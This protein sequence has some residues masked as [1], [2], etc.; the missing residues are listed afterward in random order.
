[1]RWVLWAAVGG[2]LLMGA[3]SGNKEDTSTG[4][5]ER[6][7]E[8]WEEKWDNGHKELEYQYYHDP[9]GVEVKHGYYREYSYYVNELITTDGNYWEG[10]KAGEWY[11]RC[12]AGPLPYVFE[13]G[14][15]EMGDFTGWRLEGVR[16]N[17]IELVTDESTEKGVYSTRLTLYP[18][19]MI[20]GG[21]RVE[22][23]RLDPDNL[24]KE[25]IYSWSFKVD[26][27]YKEEPYWQAICQFHSQPDS[28]TGE[29]WDTYPAYKPPIS[30]L[31]F[32]RIC[33]VLLIPSDQIP[34]EIGRFEI[35]KGKWFEVFFQIKWSTIEDGYIEMYV[36]DKPVTPF[37]GVDHKF[38]SSNVNNEA[39]NYLKIGLYRDSRATE[40]NTVYVDDLNISDC[41]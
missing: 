19:D 28:L 13:N 32:N 25:R 22:L 40:I 15:F 1:M 33:R 4:S 30:I 26:A 23:V 12:K 10:E 29:T 21:N 16:V 27:N 3:C 8:V 34:I 11:H 36:D 41:K 20:R 2:A 18:G 17:S 14:D 24:Q 37:N 9:A 38:H 31:Y 7:L 6:R 5:Q 39:G 35:E